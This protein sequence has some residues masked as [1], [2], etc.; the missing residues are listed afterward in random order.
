[1]KIKNSFDAVVLSTAT[2]PRESNDT[3]VEE[4]WPG[5]HTGQGGSQFQHGDGYEFA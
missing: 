1:M 5:S 2:Y 4:A 3:Q